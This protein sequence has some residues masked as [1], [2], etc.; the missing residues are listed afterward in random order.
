M[1]NLFK[2][3][4]NMLAAAVLLFAASCDEEM[5]NNFNNL[6]GN[7]L[8]FSVSSIVLPS[9]G[10][11]V[12]IEVTSPVDWTISMDCS[13]CNVEPKSGEA[14]TVLITV[15]AGLNDSGET[16]TGNLI[17]N[18]SGYTSVT[19]GVLQDP[20]SGDFDPDKVTAINIYPDSLALEVG[21]TAV[22][23][24]SVVPSTATEKVKWITFTSC[25]SVDANGKVTALSAGR[26]SVIAYVGEVRTAADL[27]SVV[28]AEC[29]VIVTAPAGPDPDEVKAIQV[30][31]S[32][33]ELKVGESAT[34]SARVEPATSTAKVKWITFSS[35]VSV[36][37]NGKVTALAAGN[38]TVYAYVG[39]VR[40]ESDLASVVSASCA[41][42][43]K[44][45]E[46]PGGDDEG[47][48]LEDPI[49]GGNWNW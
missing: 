4:L 46:N 8:K 12:T 38:A 16:R 34:L 3:F 36:D 5:M 24:A 17:L 11:S 49:N 13:W 10:G 9:A 30:S 41:V 35:S 47:S 37:A 23:S 43:V 1:K 44:A 39:D 29:P 40:S 6:T 14:G 22:L 26:G 25:I 27:A 18:A 28:S 21:K 2:A 7:A 15:S 33:I 31:P 48:S 20:F 42:V 45:E 32:S 19:A